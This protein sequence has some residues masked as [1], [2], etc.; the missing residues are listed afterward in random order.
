MPL[1]GIEVPGRAKYLVV[2]IWEALVYVQ[3]C[4][5]CNAVYTFSSENLI[6]T[7]TYFYK[8]IDFKL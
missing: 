7:G 4:E 2:L 1:L 6:L 8:E 5:Y 3:N